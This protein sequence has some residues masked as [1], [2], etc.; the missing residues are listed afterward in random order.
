MPKIYYRNQVSSGSHVRVW[1]EGWDSDVFR[2]MNRED[3]D[4]MREL[5]GGAAEFV[6]ADAED[7]R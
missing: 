5:V 7:G 4:T 3:F 6:D 2:V 1:G